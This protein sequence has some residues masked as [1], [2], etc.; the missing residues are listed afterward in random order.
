VTLL[1]AAPAFRLRAK[2][3]QVKAGRNLLL[4]EIFLAFDPGEFVGVLG[5]SGCGKSTL[6]RALAGLQ[7]KSTGAVTVDGVAVEAL[8]AD[9]KSRIGFV[10]QDDIV[11]GPL[12]VERALYYSARLRSIPDAE[13]APRL[14]EVIAQLGLLERR[15]TRIDRLSGGQRKRVSIGVELLTRPFLIFLDEPTA[16]L[17]PA[18][19]EQFMDLCRD[20][21]RSARTVIMSTHVMQSLDRLDSVVIMLTGWIQWVGPPAQALSYF[22]VSHLHEVYKTL[23]TQDPK[24]GWEKFR[25]TPF[26]NQFVAARMTT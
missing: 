1:Q 2:N 15:K 25:N 14:D 17:D 23:A 10:P 5:P 11:H 19:E 7:A 18:L 26:Y 13:I 9:V 3:V 8:S 4:Q 6:L 22:G 16:G 24:A 12:T 21:A 20:L